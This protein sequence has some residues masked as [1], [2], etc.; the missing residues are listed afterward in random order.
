M[1]QKLRSG[2]GARK[3]LHER[4]DGVPAPLRLMQRVFE[5]HVR[6]GDFVDDIEIAGLPPEFREPA[7]DDG[8]V[9]L[10]RR[11]F[12]ISLQ[13][14]GSEG[15]DLRISSRPNGN[16]NETE[17][18]QSGHPVGQPGFFDDFSGLEPNRAHAGEP[19]FPA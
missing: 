5:Q 19:H 10:F 17:L 15:N 18:I 2:N 7:A 1:P 12:N 13:V 11:H 3:S 4:L 6:C 9:A 8:F 16:P 14:E